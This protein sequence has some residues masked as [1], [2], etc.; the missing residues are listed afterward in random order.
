VCTGRQEGVGEGLGVEGSEQCVRVY[1]KP[2]RSGWGGVRTVKVY[3]GRQIGMGGGSEQFVSVCRKRGR[4]GR[5][6]VQ[7]SS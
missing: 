5:G 1:K 4:S 2:G 6:G 3:A 7:N